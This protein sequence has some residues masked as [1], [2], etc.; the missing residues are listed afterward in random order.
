MLQKRSRALLATFRELLSIPGLEPE[1]RL[2]LL[3]FRLL[4]GGC[5]VDRSVVDAAELV[6]SENIVEYVLARCAA[7][8][9][10]GNAGQ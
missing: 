5:N 6:E 4:R 9:W 3:A 7:G 2:V 8:R 10:E 1:G